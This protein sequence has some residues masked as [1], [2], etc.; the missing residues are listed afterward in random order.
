MRWYAVSFVCAAARE[1]TTVGGENVRMLLG[2]LVLVPLPWPFLRQEAKNGFSLQS[3]VSGILLLYRTPYVKNY[4]GRG[5][6]SFAILKI[7]MGM[8]HGWAHASPRPSTEVEPMERHRGK[9]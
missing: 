4:L 3:L 6:V 5:G 2:A 9:L 7:W 8:D 1:V